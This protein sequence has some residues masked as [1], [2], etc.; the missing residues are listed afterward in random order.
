MKIEHTVT[1]QNGKNVSITVKI[2]DNG[3][4][5]VKH[6]GVGNKYH[7]DGTIWT[8][9]RL[10]KDETVKAVC[11]NGSVITETGEHPIKL[12]DVFRFKIG[13]REGEWMVKVWK[14]GKREPDHDYFTD[15]EE[16]A[17]NTLDAMKQ[18]MIIKGH[19]VI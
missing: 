11:S 3:N 16:D 14:N 12:K 17:R 1:L 19:T 13:T 18:E 4:V 15:D 5:A 6:R 2:E 9:I 7:E 10:L 8:D